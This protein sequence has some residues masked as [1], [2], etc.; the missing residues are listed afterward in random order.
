MEGKDGSHPLK[1]DGLGC[2]GEISPTGKVSWRDIRVAVEVKGAWPELVAQAATYSCCMFASSRGQN[3][4]LVIEFNR[5]TCE[6]RFLFFHRG[7][8]TACPAVLKSDVGRQRFIVAMVGLA[9][10][11]DRDSA[12]M[13]SSRDNSR[14]HLP[15]VG[16]CTIVKTMCARDC[17]RGRATFVARLNRAEKTPNPSVSLPTPKSRDTIAVKV[18]HTRSKEPPTAR[19]AIDMP[20]VGSPPSNSRV[21]TGS[22]PMGSGCDEISIDR[23]CLEEVDG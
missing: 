22:G 16:L 18:Y 13:D 1:P 2:N 23:R 8:E 17:V 4:N 12:G 14:F 20:Q 10:I 5:K 19:P 15:A 9:S 21:A 11:I 3:Y 7:D 6:V